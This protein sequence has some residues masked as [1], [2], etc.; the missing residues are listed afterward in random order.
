MSDPA[1]APHWDIVNK[2]VHAPPGNALGWAA[3]ARVRHWARAA[4]AAAALSH[5][6]H[7]RRQEL[8]RLNRRHLTCHPMNGCQCTCAKPH[9]FGQLFSIQ[10]SIYNVA[11]T[12]SGGLF[13]SRRTTTTHS[14]HALH[15]QVVP[16]KK[17]P[18]LA[19]PGGSDDRG[20]SRGRGRWRRGR[21]CCPKRLALLEVKRVRIPVAVE[22]FLRVIIAIVTVDRVGMVA[23]V[24]PVAVVVVQMPQVTRLVESKYREQVRPNARHLLAKRAGLSYGWVFSLI[25]STSTSAHRYTY[26]RPMVRTRK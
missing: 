13:C 19:C 10:Y 9:L 7:S 6:D 15:R 8:P 20:R 26:V 5:D 23:A 16:Q 3:R 17:A 14:A 18:S 24:L 21:C 4:Q 11:L 2:H 25:L 12:G 22:I 1:G